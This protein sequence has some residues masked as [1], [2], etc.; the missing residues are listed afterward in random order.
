MRP[1]ERLGALARRALAAI[2]SF[3]AAAPPTSCERLATA[4]GEHAALVTLHG[5][6][7]GRPAQRDLGVVFGDDF[8]AL[9]SAV[10]LDPARG[11]ATTALVRELVLGDSHVLGVRRRRYEYAPPPGWQAL[12]RGFVTDWLPP[13]APADSTTLAIYPASPTALSSGATI[14]MMV[15]AAEQ[16]AALVRQDPIVSLRTAAGLAGAAVE[17]TLR[18]AAGEL[19]KY[20][21]ALHDARYLYPLEATARR[22]DDFAPHRPTFAD[23][24]ETIRPVPTGERSEAHAFLAHWTV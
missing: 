7:R 17:I 13:G 20:L 6:E 21:A 9:T 11:P 8:Y 18:D 22:L 10:C 23:V 15:R 24:I 3:R 14:R 19:V 1:L 5:D 16:D 2:P 4:E 12:A